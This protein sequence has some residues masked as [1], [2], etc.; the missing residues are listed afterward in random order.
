MFSIISM[1]NHLYADDTIIIHVAENQQVLKSEL[2]EQLK[3]LAYW[4]RQNKLTINTKKCEVIFF[5]SKQKLKKCKEMSP[6]VLDEQVL[7][8]KS[9]V[10]YLGVIFD[11]ELTWKAHTGGIRKKVGYKLSKIKNIQCYLSERTKKQLVNA[12]I[13]PY[14]HYCSVVWSSAAVSTLRKLE[15]QYVRVKN[16]YGPER[17]VRTLL[18]KN[19]SLFT[20]KAIH[21]LSP[22]YISDKISLANQ[23]RQR[24]TRQSI[25]NHLINDAAYRNR[26][27]N[28]TFKHVASSTWNS[29]PPNITCETSLVR[30]KSKIKNFYSSFN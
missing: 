28:I 26:F 9:K 30:F 10:K 2:E 4:F 22:S 14:Y 3:E 23:S 6:V 27:S 24:V 18:D 25:N 19:L 15:S 21:K 7:E 1:Y 16:I 8:T 29:L 17:S 13:M 11:E 12:L 20:F 5:G